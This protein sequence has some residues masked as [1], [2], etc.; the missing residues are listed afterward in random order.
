MRTIPI[1]MSLRWYRVRRCLPILLAACPLLLPA[2]VLDPPAL[3]CTAVA[4]NGD[5]TLTWL[6]PSDPTN[7]FLRYDLYRADAATGPFTLVGSV[8]VY[9]QLSQVDAG[10]NAGAAA[11]YYYLTTVSTSA[12]PNVSLPS[13]TVASLFV[14][15]SQSVP[16]GSAVVDWTPLHTPALPTSAAHTLLD[17]EHPVGTW[18]LTDSVA[19]PV[20]HWSQV[21]SICD[22]SLNFRVHLADASG[23]IS[24]SNA[25]GARFQDVTPPSMP[26]MVEVTVDTTADHSLLNW[27]PSP[28]A[29]TQGY[30][31]VQSTPGGNVIIDTVFGRLNTSYLWAG[32][33]AGAGPESF[34][35]AAIDTCERGV[36]PSPNTSAT[37]DPHTTIFLSTVYDRCAGTIRIQRTPY[38]GWPVD[39]YA[40]YASLDGGA[41]ALLTTLPPEVDHYDLLSVATGHVYRFVLQAFGAGVSSLSNKAERTTAYPPVPQWNYLRNVTVSGPDLITITDSVDLSAFMRNLVLERSSNGSPWEAIATVPGGPAPV[42]TFTD[43]DVLTAERSYSYRVAAE[44]S[45]GERTAI[46]NTGNSML[47]TVSPELDGFN[48]L[49]WNGYSVWAG[50]VAGHTV[51]QSIAD[52][53]FQAVGTTAATTWQYADNVQDLFGTPGKFCYYV[54]SDEAGNPAGINAVSTSNIACAVQQ[55]EVWVPN[56]FI[57]GGANP[58]FKPVLAYADVARYEFTIFNRWGQPIWTTTDRDQAWDGRMNGRLVPQ[59]VYAYY[60]SFLNGA[61]KTVERRGTVTFLPG[62]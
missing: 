18:T 27:E 15:V 54:R 50:N 39:H 1:P 53:P 12:P 40:L 28:E 59:G 25:T 26:I 46:S 2:A 16:L 61:G 55:E 56:A 14:Q 33:Q 35:I 37:L 10:A 3:R 52:G 22:D 42:V 47:L 48:H 31:I 9:T 4:T 51:F 58:L 32:S 6:A 11:R 19:D 57:S 20:H 34:T 29:D 17:M 45:C 62:R 24:S 43:T 23:C 5:V 41:Y 30:I 21:V 60:C 13:D 44:D 49:Y 36:P 38:G 7:S 8:P